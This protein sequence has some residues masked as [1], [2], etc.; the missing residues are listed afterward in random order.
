MPNNNV[1]ENASM[2]Q[3]RELLMGTQLKDM[4]NRILRMEE[5]FMQEIADVRDT[6]KNRADSLENFMKS[7]ASSLMHR[8]QEEKTERTTAVKTEQRERADAIKAEHKDRA[9]AMKQDRRERDD[10][11]A[12]TAKELAKLNE[13]FERKMTA[14]SVTLDTV[15]QELRQLLLAESSRLSVAAEEKYKDALAAISRTAAQLQ[16]DHVS[17]SALSATFTEFAVK[18][19]GDLTLAG[20]GETPGDADPAE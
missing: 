16:H 14:L 4:E 8:L 18:L 2:E 7:E 11:F 15:E 13:D 5:R 1:S 10:T 12:K 9:E 6:V 20:N 3:V 19:V 17:R